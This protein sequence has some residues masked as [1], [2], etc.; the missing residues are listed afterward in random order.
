MTEKISLLHVKETKHVVGA[1]TH[2]ADPDSKATA[3]Q[4]APSGVLVR[5]FTATPGTVFTFLVPA[6]ELDVINV[7]FDDELLL[8]PRGFLIDEDKAASPIPANPSVNAATL[9]ATRITVGVS[10]AV[11]D[12]TPVWVQIAGGSLTKPIIKSGKIDKTQTSVEFQFDRL[13]AGTYQIFALATG[14]SPRL[15]THNI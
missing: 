13:T 5:D 6:D 8:R 1:V 9:T 12:D 15:E 4:L 14:H 2:T 7:D 10:A 11:T 3:A